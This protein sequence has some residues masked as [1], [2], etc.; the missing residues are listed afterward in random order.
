[1]I[2]TIK[3]LAAI[4]SEDGVVHTIPSKYIVSIDVSAAFAFQTD[5]ELALGVAPPITATIVFKKKTNSTQDSFYQLLGRNQAY[6]GC[7]ITTFISFDNGVTY[8]TTFAGILKTRAES[9]TELTFQ[10]AGFLDILNLKKISTP[11][12]RWSPV[13]TKIPDSLGTAQQNLALLNTQNPAN[14]RVGVINSIL[15]E[16][17]GRPYKYK[18]VYDQNL[19]QP[20]PKF[21]FDCD[22]SLMNPEWIWFNYDNLLN[23]LELLCRASGGVLFQNTQ[24]IVQYQN[25]YG[26][27]AGTQINLKD[28][29]YSSL[30][31]G[32][33][34]LEPYSRLMMTFTPRF[35]SGSQEVFS[36]TLDE[37]LVGPQV[38]SKVIEFQKP[39]A[40]LLNK[41]VSGQLADTLV[42]TQYQKTTELVQATSP[43]LSKVPVYFRIDPYVD[44]YLPKYTFAGTL[45][46]FNEGRDTNRLPSQSAKIYMTQSGVYSDYTIFLNNLKLFGRALE[47]SKTQNYIADI[48]SS[49]VY[50]GFRELK[51]ND[52]PYVQSYQ[53][54]ERYVTIAQYLIANPRDVITLEGVSSAKS[55]ELGSL[56]NLSSTLMQ[57]S[58][59]YKVTGLRYDNSGS[60]AQVTLIS[61]GDLIQRSSVYI[62]GSGYASSETKYLGF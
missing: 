49:G 42:S 45:G 61:A 9:F 41:T 60:S 62:V 47:P 21:Y 27:R 53:E 13:A 43:S 46:V 8:K 20:K 35:L 24:G 10:A 48:S 31:F 1:M 19:A 15:W 30:S 18:N 26:I 32:E 11:L 29:D 2:H 3:Y 54:A 7:T 38:V 17:G 22:A 28:S 44:W 25:V 6:R 51:L 37:I 50:S 33:S 34:R 16:I 52:N 23:D 5:T 57:V 39:V 14:Y 36:D 55:L 12:L 58:G 59:L 56:I 4:T 40:Y